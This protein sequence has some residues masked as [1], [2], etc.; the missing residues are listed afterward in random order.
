[1][2]ENHHRN[3]TQ[4]VVFS[5]NTRETDIAQE[6]SRLLENGWKVDAEGNGIEKEYHFEKSRRRIAILRRYR[7]R[8][9]W[10][11]T[12]SSYAYIGT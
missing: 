9:I 3:T 1:M 5:S 4:A 7:Q 10:V 6:L 11:Q 2:A 8:N 12:A